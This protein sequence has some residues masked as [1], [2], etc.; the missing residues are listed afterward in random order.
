M[1]P[2]CWLQPASGAATRSLS[3]ALRTVTIAA[4]ALAAAAA[5]AADTAAATGVAQAE[6]QSCGPSSRYVVAYY[7]TWKRQSL[8]NVDWATISHVHV[9]H[10]IP[11]DSGD[12]TFDGEWFL[13]QLVRDAHAAHTKVSLSLGGWTGSNRLSSIMRD[14]HK[15]ATLIRSLGAFVEKYELDGVDID[16]EY[17]G[18]QGSKCNKVAPAEDAANLLRFLRALRASLHARFPQQQ[19]GGGGSGEQ[20]DKLV[21]LA[22]RVQPFD[23]ADGPMSDVSAFAEYVDYA[24]LLAFDVNGAW[25]NTTGPNAPLDHQRGRGAPYSLRQAVTQWLDAKWPADKLVAGI[26]YSGRSLTT[27][28]V[29]TAKQ[30]A[31]MYALFDRDVPQGDPEDARWYDVCENTNMMSGVWQYRHLRDQGILQAHNVSSAEWVRV[32]DERSSTPWLYNAQ[33]RRFVSYDDP[34]SVEMKVAFAR[35][36]KLKGVM[37]WGLHGDY[38]GELAKEMASIGPLC[39]GPKSDKDA[40]V[41]S[42]SAAATSSSSSS[43]SPTAPMA[44]LPTP[45][46]DS[47]SAS[48]ASSA[49]ASASSSSAASSSSSQAS[50]SSSVTKPT[51]SPTNAAESASTSAAESASTSAAESA[52]ASTADSASTTPPSSSSESSASTT[53]KAILFNDVGA[54]YVMVDGT[55][56]PVPSELAEKLMKLGD[57]QQPSTSASPATAT[58]TDSLPAAASTS[59]T[60]DGLPLGPVA[61]PVVDGPAPHSPATPTTHEPDWLLQNHHMTNLFDTKPATSG[62]AGLSSLSA[63]STLELHGPLYFPSTSGSSTGFAAT[64]FLTL[65]P[66]A[67]SSGG[68]SV[69]STTVVPLAQMMASAMSASSASSASSATPATLASI[70]P[71][72]SPS[73]TTAASDSLSFSHL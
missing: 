34:Q 17:V 24:S 11:L 50:D 12:F 20:G 6:P 29:L 30:N 67:Q 57:A 7:P 19:Q 4:L 49:S 66:L 9:A 33:M 42:T 21:S 65:D 61:I 28:G 43:W 26:S 59:V 3:H 39:R 45:T 18:R 23:T 13:P 15:R 48:S 14:T 55:S 5:A 73:A 40:P 64:F 53:R 37:A 35:D 27:Q 22:L 58:G 44:F 38:R 31:S 10:A 47:S 1:H 62:P 25:S 16:W 2:P 46:H 63:S 52:P 71:L 68:A 51:E 54:P 32:W 8:M 56:S 41:S 60:D 69:S 70:D 36:M 72:A